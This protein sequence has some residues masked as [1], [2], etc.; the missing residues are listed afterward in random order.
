MKHTQYAA[1]DYAKFLC[2]LIILLYHYFSEIHIISGIFENLLSLYAV[3]VALFMVISGFLFGTKQ[4]SI[5]E[6]SDRKKALWRQVKRIFTIYLLWSILYLCYSISRWDFTSI[7]IRFVLDKMQGWVFNST[8]YT[9]W[10]MP[11]L[12]VG[13][14]LAFYSIEYLGCVKTSFLAIFSYILGALMMTYSFVGNNIP[15]FSAFSEFVSNWM[16]GARGGVFFGFPLCVLGI[17]ISR[18]EENKR[19]IKWIFLSVFSMLCLLCEAVLL[20]VYIGNTGIDLT[21]TMPFVVYCVMNCLAS[22]KGDTTKFAVLLREMSVLIFMSQRIF[23]T[24]L[25]D[26]FP[27][28][29]QKVIFANEGISFFAC[30]GGTIVFSICVIALSERII[31]LKKVY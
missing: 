12:A 21:M 20:K 7:D 29:Y 10:F 26:V 24:V 30:C 27:L 14:I 3:A 16:Q 19:I 8:F 4:N 18:K 2:A 28:F 25:P 15:G 22:I 11:S 23:L 31:V 13:L 9:I 5:D 17:I 1:I 6:E